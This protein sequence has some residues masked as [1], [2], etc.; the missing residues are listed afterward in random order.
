MLPNCTGHPFGSH[1][2]RR[3]GF[4]ARTGNCAPPGETYTQPRKEAY[5]GGPEAGR[6]GNSS[7]RHRQLRNRDPEERTKTDS[8]N[9]V[10]RTD[11]SNTSN[12]RSEVMNAV[13]CL[14]LGDCLR[15]CSCEL[16]HLQCGVYNHGTSG[17]DRGL[18]Y[19]RNPLAR[20]RKIRSAGIYI[21]SLSAF[22]RNIMGHGRR[23]EK[24]SLTGV[25][26]QSTPFNCLPK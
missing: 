12:W 22:S 19:L 13:R 26:F 14:R 17:R 7:S 25:C 1:D 11:S 20:N 8:T 18:S 24:R 21:D 5:D 15:C 10:V 23:C 9:V 2:L 6:A 4:S 3:L 16:C